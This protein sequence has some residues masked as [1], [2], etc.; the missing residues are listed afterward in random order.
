MVRVWHGCCFFIQERKKGG[1]MST[2]LSEHWL[3]HRQVVSLVNQCRRLI[4]EEFAVVLRLS[5]AD[6][7]Q[8]LRHYAGVSQDTRIR[9]LLNE[10]DSLAPELQAEPE[11]PRQMY[12]GQAVRSEEKR[13]LAMAPKPVKKSKRMYRGRPVED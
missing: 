8:Q 12:R 1:G 3:M 5:D 9:A 7:R 6:L 13:S 10:I 2:G 4:R 11:A